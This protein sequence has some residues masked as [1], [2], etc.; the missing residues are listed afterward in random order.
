MKSVSQ[1]YIFKTAKLLLPKFL[2]TINNGVIFKNR[3]TDLKFA[4]FIQIKIYKIKT[5][6]GSGLHFL[7][8]VKYNVCTKNSVV[9]YIFLSKK[10]FLKIL[11]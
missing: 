9:I 8:S 2:C 4:F 3:T 7:S 1:I 5:I 6:L 11:I 10:Y